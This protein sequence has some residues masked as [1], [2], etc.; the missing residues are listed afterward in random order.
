ME[1]PTTIISGT[2]GYIILLCICLATLQLTR[3]TGM[4]SKDNTEIGNV[5][6]T[7]ASFAMWLFW[8][9]AWMHQW[10]PLIQ[11]IYEG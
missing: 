1:I 7:I 3:A 9:C 6:V 5:V 4:L 11:P 10:H 2:V 8:F